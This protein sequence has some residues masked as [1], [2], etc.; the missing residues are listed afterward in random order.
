[1]TGLGPIED[2]TTNFSLRLVNFDAIGWGP[3]E[4]Q[5]WQIVDA[6]LFNVITLSNVQGIW[7]NAITVT[8]GQRYVDEADGTMWEVLIGHTTASSP[9][10]F[11]QDRAANPGNWQSISPLTPIYKGLWDND[12][13]YSRND[14]VSTN[15]HRYAVASVSH[16]SLSAPNDFDDDISNWNVIIDLGPTVTAAEAAQTAAELAETN[17]ETAETNAAASESAA[18][19][20]ESNA[21]TSEANA[22]TS[23]TNA[24]A[25]ASAAA[26]SETNAGTSETNA[27]SSASAA[28]TSETNAAASEAAAAASEA[29]AG[30]SETNAATSETNAAASEAAAAASAQQA[31]AAA[32]VLSGIRE[33]ITASTDS[34]ATD[35]GKLIEGNRATAQALIVKKNIHT[36]F[37]VFYLEQ[38]GDGQVSINADGA[39]GV[40]FR[41]D[42]VNHTLATHAKGSKVTII[43]VDDTVDAN[44]FSVGGALALA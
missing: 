41:Y 40:S 38:V 5:N 13:I 31:A 34:I 43:C 39:G 24:A 10:T 37:D 22:A 19:T 28:A 15:D 20:S 2:F 7:Q 29:N 42:D 1:M 4:H 21:A 25:S 35:V 17:A 30:T 36:Q 44:V 8:V 18:A 27:A 11:A 14:F 3:F 9:T 33:F 16:T 32:G 23:E 6:L 12:V 26:T